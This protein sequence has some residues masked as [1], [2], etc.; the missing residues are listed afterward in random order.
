[1]V[2]MGIVK[3]VTRPHHVHAS[4][5][6]YLDL[7][8]ILRSGA[9]YSI[10]IVN[11]IME[12]AITNYFLI[13]TYDYSKINRIWDYC[14]YQGRNIPMYKTRITMSQTGWVVE[15]PD[16]KTQTAFLLNFANWVTKVGKPYYL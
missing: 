1:M 11:T 3:M 15:L 4:S 12:R 10:A 14:N 9:F 7:P 6:A 16:D 13:E 2:E 5:G 8:P